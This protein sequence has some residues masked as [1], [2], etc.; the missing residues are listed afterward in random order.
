MK[1][2]VF[3]FNANQYK[4]SEGDEILVEGTQGKEGAS[5]QAEKVLLFVDD[6]KALVGTPEVKGVFVKGKILGAEKGRKLHV[7]K[8]KAKSRY[9]RQMGHRT[10]YSVVEIEKLSQKG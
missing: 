9:R 5:L 6:G 8:Y 10:Q 4:A 2:A 7:S 3:T 1:Y